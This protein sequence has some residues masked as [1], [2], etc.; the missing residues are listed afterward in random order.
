MS[1]SHDQER[2]ER[3]ALV[4]ARSNT[5]AYLSQAF[6]RVPTE[7][8]V[9]GFLDEALISGLPDRMEDGSEHPLRRFAKTY[10]GDLETL[11]QEF[12]ALFVAPIRGMY[13]TPYASVYLTGIMSQEPMRA[14]RQIYQEAGLEIDHG[15]AD[16]P[17]HIGMELEFMAVLSDRES[18]ALKDGAAAEVQDLLVLQQRFLT[19]HLLP[20][21]PQLTGEI[22]KRGTSNF[23]GGISMFMKDFVSLDRHLVDE[24][25]GSKED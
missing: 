3:L 11:S 5:Y 25:L 7:E 21:I 15:S 16:S 4:E 20:W 23:Y 12:E 22:I 13:V 19:G 1:T 8:L 2:S 17:D 10:D 24:M 18:S 14:T 9:N 6:L